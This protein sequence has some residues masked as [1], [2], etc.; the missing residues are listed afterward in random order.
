MNGSVN[1]YK[2]RRIEIAERLTIAI[3]RDYVSSSLVEYTVLW[4]LTDTPLHSG[5]R[6]YYSWK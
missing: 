5:N 1:E 4:N 6:D 2:T 3:A